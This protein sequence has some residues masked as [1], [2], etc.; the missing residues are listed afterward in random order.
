MLYDRNGVQLMEE[1]VFVEVSSGD[2]FIVRSMR[3]MVSRAHGELV[4]VCCHGMGLRSI[5]YPVLFNAGVHYR[6]WE[7]VLR[8]GAF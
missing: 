6:H 2:L 1:D 3:R 7:I 8:M 4:E 5:N